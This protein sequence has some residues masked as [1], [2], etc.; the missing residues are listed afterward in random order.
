MKFLGTLLLIAVVTAEDLKQGACYNAVGEAIRC[1]PDFINIAF[2][3]QVFASNTCGDP[4][5][6]FCVQQDI[7]LPNIDEGDCYSCDASEFN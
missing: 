4:P 1:I 2:Q 3:A 5:S 7:G 6:E